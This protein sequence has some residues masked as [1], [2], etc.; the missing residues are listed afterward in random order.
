VGPPS[1]KVQPIL[2]IE[3]SKFSAKLIKRSIA[4][5]L[6]CPVVVAHSASE[7]REEL[8][9]GG[10][11][12]LA[13]VTDL[14]LP[15]APRGEVVDLLLEAGLPTVVLTASYD[16]GTRERI[17]GRGIVDYHIKGVQSLGLV[18]ETLR[19]LVINPEV[20]ILIVDDSSAYRMLLR[21]L[22]EAHRFQVLEA[23]DGVEGLA[24]VEAHPEVS[25]VITDFEMP[26][27][28]GVELVGHIRARRSA[29]ELAILGASSVGSGS[30][31]ARFLKFGADDFINKPFLNEEFYC[32]VYHSLKMIEHIRAVQRAAYTDQLTGLDNRLSF[33]KTVPERYKAAKSGGAPFAV[34]MMDI[35][36]FK[37]INDTYGHAGGDVALRHLAALLR[38]RL[39]ACFVARFG[40]EEFCLVTE[41]LDGASV[42]ELLEQVRA[43]VEAST[44]CFE[45]EIIR[46][47][48]SIG[49]TTSFDT[50]LD[51]MINRADEALYLA[52]ETGRNRVVFKE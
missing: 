43:A 22:L 34:A 3:D 29:D 8:A 10:A 1:T 14:D 15:D 52:K 35:D 33:F 48:L 40:G 2:L 18:N 6:R 42:Q 49:C 32:R 25:L 45:D 30:L 28:D 39:G 44:V 26:N 13:A 23:A 46:F 9:Q 50:S 41:E 4:E 12:F 36:F 16:E 19:R 38:E 11:S 51:A 24:M 7:A 17:L 20:K 47:T 27:M 37:K 5:A 21:R 31:S